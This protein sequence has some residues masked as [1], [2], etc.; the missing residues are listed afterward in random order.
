VVLSG[1]PPQQV[2]PEMRVKNK[3]GRKKGKRSEAKER[4]RKEKRE[5]IGESNVHETA[6]FKIIMCGLWA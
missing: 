5:G 1:A 4:E 2:A 3:I 6:V